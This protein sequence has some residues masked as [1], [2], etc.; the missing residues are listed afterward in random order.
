MKG[1]DLQSLA[2]LCFLDE[3]KKALCSGQQQNTVTSCRG[4]GFESL[5]QTTGQDICRVQLTA[6]FCV[7]FQPLAR[8]TAVEVNTL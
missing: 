3:K 1:N 4:L 7:V 8:F 6:A 2:F 5:F